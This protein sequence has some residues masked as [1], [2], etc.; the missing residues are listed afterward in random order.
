MSWMSRAGS[1]SRATI[2]RYFA[3]DIWPWPRM[4]LALVRISWG[5]RTVGVGHVSL[6]GDGQE[7][8]VDAGGVDG[9]DGVDAGDDGGDDRA[10]QLVDQ[11]AERGVLLG[12]AADR[13]ERPDRPVA[14]VDALDAQHGEVVREAVIAEVVAERALGLAACGIDRCRR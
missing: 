1:S 6:A 4:A 7:Q 10:G 9:V 14:V 11:R 12:R 3:S 5:R 13:G 8:R 2:S